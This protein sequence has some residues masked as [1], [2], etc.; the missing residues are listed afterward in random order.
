MSKIIA[1]NGSPHA[2]GN[3]SAMLDFAFSIAEKK[4]IETEK[5]NLSEFKIKPCLACG[6]CKTGLTCAIKDDG[7]INL[8][9]K[10]IE[11]DAI[12][13]ASPTY[14]GSMTAQI[15]AWMD[16]SV[17][18]RRNGFLLRDKLGAALAVGGS[19]NGGQELVLTQLHGFM[20]IHGMLI[21]GDDNHF[22]GIVHAPFAEDDFGKQ[23]VTDTIEKVCRILAKNS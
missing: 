5:I 23:T 1:I 17:A 14:M 6:I 9:D 11:A 10:F 2:N 19:R 12:I 21:V 16:R 8:Y 7:M 3:T 20:H 18:L 15:K 13:L 22:G 4:G